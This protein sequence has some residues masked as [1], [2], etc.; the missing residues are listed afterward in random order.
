MLCLAAITIQFTSNVFSPDYDPTIGEYSVCA[1]VYRSVYVCA[2]IIRDH[3]I[4][5]TF[6]VPLVTG[7]GVKKVIRMYC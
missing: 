2:T 6:S 5:T 1:V 4:M 3:G 7:N